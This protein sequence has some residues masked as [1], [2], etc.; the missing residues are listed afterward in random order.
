MAIEQVTVLGSGPAFVRVSAR[1]SRHCNQCDLKNGCGHQML[2]GAVSS[3][4]AFSSLELPIYHHDFLKPGDTLD[5]AIDEGRLMALSLLHYG[6]PALA[7]FMAA[8]VSRSL[9]AGSDAGES[10]VI[11][12]TLCALGGALALVRL[13]AAR[14]PFPALLA[15]HNI[16]G[17]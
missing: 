11:A 9:A 7:M 4:R 6:L 1:D 2:A 8:A 15:V 14:L 3:Q 10:W 5:L 17:Q 12:A 13:I 16:R